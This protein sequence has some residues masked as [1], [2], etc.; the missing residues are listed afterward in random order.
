VN[1]E[2]EQE[3]QRENFETHGSEPEEV[4]PSKDKKGFET[5]NL[6]QERKE[7]VS[8]YENTTGIEEHIDPKQPIDSYQ[9]LKPCLS[10]ENINSGPKKG[11]VLLETD[12]PVINE[13]P[14]KK[15]FTT[16][17]QNRLDLLQNKGNLKLLILRHKM[18]FFHF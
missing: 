5:P 18:V 12:F 14:H 6:K 7:I 17:E 3:S 1:Q 9:D 16:S 11:K 4:D 15:T 2:I 10:L 8:C 13:K